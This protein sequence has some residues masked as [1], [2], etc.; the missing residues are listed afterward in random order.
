MQSQATH[1]GGAIAARCRLRLPLQAGSSRFARLA[2]GYV[3]ATALWVVPQAQAQAQDLTP[4]GREALGSYMARATGSRGHLGAVTL[5]ARHGKVLEL[6]AYGYRDLQ[7]QMPMT[8]DS[9][10]R[11]YSMSKSVAAVATLILME[12][13]RLK[14]DD[15]VSRHLR[16]FEHLQVFAGGSASAPVLRAPQRPLTIRHLLTHTPGFA[17]GGRDIKAASQL[18]ERADLG[19]SVDLQDFAHRV[20]RVPLAADPGERFRYDGVQFEVLGR[21][22]EAVSGLP[23]DTFVRQHIFGPLRMVDTGFTVPLPE[24]QRIVD[25]STINAANRL[26]LDSG[27]SS[28]N[29]GVMLRPYFSLA[30]GLY[31][32]APDFMRFCQML[33]NGGTLEGATVLAPSSV[34]LMLSNQLMQL[35]PPAGALPNEAR[36]GEGMG[37]GG[38]VI[39]DSPQRRRPGSVGSFGWSGAA[40]TYFMIDPKLQLAAIL[41]LQHLPPEEGEDLPKHSGKFYDRVYEALSP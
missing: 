40:S 17:T 8:T 1:C 19:A 32:T 12:Q 5:V 21:L 35:N 13:G 23:L 15:P 3:L 31:S 25:V 41:L 4:Q 6:R 18:L 2:F 37:L 22:I 33:L 39:P 9:I 20:A 24:R 34:H 7:R 11:I 16:E 26:V 28:L 36:P 10:F 38:W 27:R 29:P 14:L 30:G